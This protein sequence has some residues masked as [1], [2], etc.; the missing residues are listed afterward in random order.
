V[1]PLCPA[2]NA[3]GVAMEQ[4]AVDLHQA[5]EPACRLASRRALMSATSLLSGSVG[6]PIRFFGRSRIRSIRGSGRPQPSLTR[7]WRQPWLFY[8]VVCLERI[9]ALPAPSCLLAEQS[10]Q[11]Q[12]PTRHDLLVAA[13]VG[14]VS[15]GRSGGYNK[16]RAG[17]PARLRTYKSLAAGQASR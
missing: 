16:K 13:R 2:L 17:E 14:T 12:H 4:L 3:A 15:V 10:L 1:R 5:G 7:R 6:P 9:S 8:L 11:L